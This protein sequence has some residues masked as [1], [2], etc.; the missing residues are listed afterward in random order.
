MSDILEL[1]LLGAPEVHLAS[2]P[3][4]G[5]RSAKA[6]ALLYY[7]AV[8]RRAYT[9]P[10]LAGLL[11]GDFGEREARMSLSKTLS[12]L[13]QLLP[14]HLAITQ[15][16]VAFNWEASYCID[17]GCMHALLGTLANGQTI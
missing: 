15:Q 14:S 11:W 2:A 16:A 4:M 10:A 9:R 6:K 13:R 8:S 17:V 3:V 7:L 1:K 12:N 5:F